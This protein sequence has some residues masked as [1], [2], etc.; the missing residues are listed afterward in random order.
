MKPK[1]NKTYTLKTSNELYNNKQGYYS[2][3]FMIIIIFIWA[4]IKASYTIL[5]G[6]ILIT[7][8]I[9]IP[10]PEFLKRRLDIVISDEILSIKEGGATLWAT[11]LQDIISIDYETKGIFQLGARKAMIIRNNKNDSYYQSLDGLSFGK[12]KHEEVISDIKS[13]CNIT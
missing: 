8:I 11:P 7:L 4:F 6:P 1:N 13:L 10:T 5:I 9:L 3:A 12:L 2:L